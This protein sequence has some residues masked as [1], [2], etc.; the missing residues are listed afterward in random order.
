MF[1]SV[2]HNATCAGAEETARS[3]ANENDAALRASYFVST[4]MLSIAKDVF[5]AV[6]AY[7]REAISL[8]WELVAGHR[9]SPW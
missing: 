6:V 5:S 4:L 9:F 2:R 8:G 1:S 3:L 7:E